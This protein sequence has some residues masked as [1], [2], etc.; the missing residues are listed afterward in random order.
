MLK[1]VFRLLFSNKSYV[2]TVLTAIKPTMH[3]VTFRMSKNFWA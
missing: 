2:S 3:R 1:T